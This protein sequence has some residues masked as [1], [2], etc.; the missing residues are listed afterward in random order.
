MNKRR[1]CKLIKR[2]LENPKGITFEDVDTL[3]KEF[4]YEVKQRS[5]GSSH[6]NY[7]KIGKDRITI[8][9]QKPLKIAYIR[10]VI[11]ELELEVFYDEECK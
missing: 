5:R 9:K 7:R 1:L 2:F 3:L 6:Y 10:L 8:P 11:R 4:G